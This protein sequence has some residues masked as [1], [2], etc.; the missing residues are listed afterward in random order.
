MKGASAPRV[1]VARVGVHL[2]LT[3]AE[4]AALCHPD[5]SVAAFDAHVRP[6]LPVVRIGR[7]VF[8]RRADVEAWAADCAAAKGIVTPWRRPSPAAAR[9]QRQPSRTPEQQAKV[10]AIRARLEARCSRAKAGLPDA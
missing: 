5:L 3:R 4:A 7:R 2:L 1:D 6:E 10:D 8:F 9:G